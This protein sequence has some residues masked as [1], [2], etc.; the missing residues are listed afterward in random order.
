[1]LMTALQQVFRCDQCNR[2]LFQEE[3]LNRH[4]IHFHNPVCISLIF[5]FVA[6]LTLFAEQSLSMCC[7]GVQQNLCKKQSFA[8]S[9]STWPF[10]RTRCKYYCRLL[11]TFADLPKS[12]ALYALNLVVLRLSTLILTCRL[13][14][15]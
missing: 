7:S 5:I 9:Y 3:A 11:Q 15:G 12:R 4:M 1:M 10:E 14:C 2:P 13:I 8:T 6:L